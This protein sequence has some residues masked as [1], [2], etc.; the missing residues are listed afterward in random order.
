[1]IPV[2]DLTKGTNDIN[3]CENAAKGLEIYGAIVVK[4]DKYYNNDEFMDLVE[5]YFNQPIEELRKD[6]RPQH[7]YQVGATI[8]QEKAKC[9]AVSVG[10]YK[11][12]SI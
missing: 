8:G 1:M 3:E 5:D 4:T 9:F 7:S 12:P 11:I 10:M 6:E 2:I